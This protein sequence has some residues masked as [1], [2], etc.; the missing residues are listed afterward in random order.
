M[1]DPVVETP[2][3]NSG[4][5][6]AMEKT[7]DFYWANVKSLIGQLASP[8]DVVS[9]THLHTRLTDAVNN[10]DHAMSMVP[11]PPQPVV[12]R[13]VDPNVKAAAD[14]AEKDTKSKP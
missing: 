4:L 14:R 1:A 11:A 9:F 10:L 3:D 13:V 6:K 2:P 5:V 7:V 12:T 8:M